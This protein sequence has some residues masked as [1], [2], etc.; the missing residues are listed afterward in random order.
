MDRGPDPRRRLADAPAIAAV[1]LYAVLSLATG[2]AGEP[3]HDEGGTWE[4]A[5]APL[6]LVAGEPLPISTLY[7]A[8][9]GATAHRPRDV[10][11]ALL[12]TYGMHPPA[13]YL[14]MNRWI[15]WTGGRPVLVGVPAA[16]LCIAALFAMRSLAERV[17]P[18]PRAGRRAMFLLAVSPWLVGY[19]VIARPYAMALALVVLSSECLLRALSARGGLPPR[20]LFVALSLVGIY[21]VYHYAFVVAWQLALAAL[22]ALR[23]APPAR[24]RELRGLASIS[25]A[26][27]LGYAPWLPSLLVHLERTR[28]P[29]YFSGG[30]SAQYWPLAAAGLLG[31][32]LL[33]EERRAALRPELGAALLLLVAVTLPFAARSFARARR[34]AEDSAARA[35]WQS[36]ALLPALVAAADLWHGTHT[37]V[38][39]KTGFAYPVL[40]G[41]LVVRAAGALP[42]VIPSAAL[43][44][45]W[46]ALAL[47]ADGSAIATAAR[48]ESSYER[49]ARH[50]RA[51]D[52]PS[53][54][55]VI[56]TAT[57]PY[58]VPFL[59]VLREA[60]VRE[61]QVVVAPPELLRADGASL[62]ERA[63]ARSL[64][65]VN[66]RVTYDLASVWDR[67]LLAEVEA[68]A[69]EA[70]WQT[71]ALPRTGPDG[72]DLEGERRLF[73]LSPVQVRYFP[74]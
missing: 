60:G 67:A 73:I 56:P 9:G 57:A 32:L 36:A 22:H 14:L 69:R 71:A 45:A 13:Y 50:L 39:G 52:D 5:V 7:D 54:L 55:L 43:V 53:H 15:P 16:L 18:G 35:F 70:G 20:V 31:S 46:G 4:H 21:T 19:T 26:I 27:A 51:H 37:L 63:G 28:E 30:V 6:P 40:L 1:L 66:L 64:S 41:L 10:V 72:P 8:V 29:W 59:L 42:R 23:A 33:G 12:S 2:L 44:A 68:R 38:L 34:A 17:A 74:G 48:T 65:L 24:G 47:V 11:R 3:T 61:V 25:A 58:V 62:A 49:V